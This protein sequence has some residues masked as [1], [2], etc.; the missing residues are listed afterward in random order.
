[1]NSSRSCPAPPPPGRRSSWPSASAPPS[2]GPGATAPALPHHT[3]SLGLAL[4]RPGDGSLSAAI[5][6][7][8]DLLYRAKM[9]GRK[10][11]AG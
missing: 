1:M 10:R 9:Q 8:D 4:T 3:V 5:A 7:A 6:R 2:P 11:V